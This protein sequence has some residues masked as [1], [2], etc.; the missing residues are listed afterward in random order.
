MAQGTTIRNFIVQATTSDDFDPVQVQRGLKRLIEL[1][2]GAVGL[3]IDGADYDAA[4]A[5]ANELSQD[6]ALDEPILIAT[7]GYAKECPWT[8]EVDGSMGRDPAMEPNYAERARLVL[9]QWHVDEVTGDAAAY[10]YAVRLIKRLEQYGLM[11]TPAG[12]VPEPGPGV[13]AVIDEL[14]ALPADH[15]PDTEDLWEA[16][17]RIESIF[18]DRNRD[19]RGHETPTGEVGQGD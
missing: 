4:D 7:P 5:M 19:D 3:I 14:D 16:L 15:E 12:Y 1:G 11:I 17:R 8:E 10:Q 9:T 2:K 6:G 18:R 13:L